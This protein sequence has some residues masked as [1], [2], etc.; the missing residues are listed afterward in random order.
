MTQINEKPEN[1][2]KPE[3]YTDQIKLAFRNTCD[4]DFQKNNFQSISGESSTPFDGTI[5]N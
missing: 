5:Y 4:R 1:S 2:R 3:K